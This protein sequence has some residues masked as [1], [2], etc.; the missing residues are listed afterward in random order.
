MAR[1]TAALPLRGLQ[2]SGGLQNL[3]DPSIRAAGPMC[4][5]VTL[6]QAQRGLS[7][8]CVFILTV[9]TTNYYS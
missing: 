7:C 4:S 1:S 5:Q 2:D 8:I 3:A 6:S 9:H